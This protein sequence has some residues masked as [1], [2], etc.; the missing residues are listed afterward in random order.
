MKDRAGLKGDIYCL[1]EPCDHTSLK[2]WENLPWWQMRKEFMIS[3]TLCIAIAGCAKQPDKI[4]ATYVSPAT[5]ASYSCK[6]IITERNSVVTRVNE[7]TGQ[8]KKK[9]DADAAAVGIGMIVFWPALFALAVGDNVKEELAS[10]K[11][12]YEALTASGKKKNCFKE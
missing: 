11:G 9:A 2:A 5:F 10:L 1:P 12:N 3:A 7:V 8:Q 6:Q 4:A